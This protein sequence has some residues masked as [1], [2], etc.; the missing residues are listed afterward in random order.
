MCIHVSKHRA[1]CVPSLTCCRPL[2]HDTVNNSV[3]VFSQ[4][5]SGAV[6]A[7]G[8]MYRFFIVLFSCP[9]ASSSV[10]LISCCSF[11]ADWRICLVFFSIFQRYESRRESTTNLVPPSFTGDALA[12]A[13]PQGR[14][15][16]QQCSAVLYG[17]RRHMDLERRTK[18][19]YWLCPPWLCRC[20]RHVAC[21]LSD[22]LSLQVHIQ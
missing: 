2:R 16:E 13:G 14:I 5:A 22:S 10:P 4:G 8:I 9:F 6:R 20:W 11:R 15:S 1:G 18:R 12:F 21:I 3:F 7:T 17:D 19:R